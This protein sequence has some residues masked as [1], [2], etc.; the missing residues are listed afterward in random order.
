MSAAMMAKLSEMWGCWSAALL[1]GMGANVEKK[2]R[3]GVRRP[4]TAWWFT[5]TG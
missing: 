4:E 1:C 3:T 2:S 5:N